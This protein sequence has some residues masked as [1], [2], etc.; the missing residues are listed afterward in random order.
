MP[1][2]ILPRS[3]APLLDQWLRTREPLLWLIGSDHEINTPQR[4]YFCDCRKRTDPHYALQF[5]VKGNGFYERNGR[6]LLLKPNMGFFDYMPGDFRYGYP[7]DATEPNDLVWVD[8][9]GPL[10]QYWFKHVTRS[11]GNVIALPEDNLVIPMML[12]IAHEYQEGVLRDRYLV[13]GLLYQLLM[14]LVSTLNQSRLATAPLVTRALAHIKRHGSDLECNVENIA[15]EL[16]CSREHLTRQFKAA[17]DVNPSDYLLQHRLR[18]A[19]QDLRATRDKLDLV[20]RRCGFSGANYF[21]RAFHRH[22]GLTPRQ[23][24]ARPWLVKM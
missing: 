5:S 19:A 7:R 21:C 23:F 17:T 22:V 18:L 3:K 10:A 8:M 2:T 6:T 16:H 24:R 15:A 20:A 4:R 14:T 13:S 11:F 1:R 9:D 12:G